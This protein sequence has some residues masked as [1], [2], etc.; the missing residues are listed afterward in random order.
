MSQPENQTAED[1]RSRAASVLR[2]LKGYRKMT[3]EDLARAVKVSR[4]KVQGYV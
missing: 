4:S 1:A 3:D 2:A